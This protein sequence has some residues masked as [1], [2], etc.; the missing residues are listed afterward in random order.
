MLNRKEITLALGGGG[1][2]GSAH[3][4][5][6]RVLERQGYTVCA[7]AGTSAGGLWG[8]LYAYG[9]SPDEIQR[10]IK[11]LDP[12]TIY[13]RQPN[14]GPAWLGLS[15]LTRML[16]DALGDI[17]FEELHI[18]FA[19]TAVDI[20]TAEYVVLRSGRV[21]DAVLATIA[22]PGVFP[23]RKVNGRL[24]IDGGVLD[25]VPVSLARSLAPSGLP[26][27]AVVLSPP[28]DY[29]DG[30][31][32]A[33]LLGSM[34]LLSSF[35]EYLGRFRITQV[36]NIMMRSVDIS[37]AM[38]TELLLEVEKP[39]VVIRPTVPQLSLLDRVDADQISLLGE[40]AAER[41]ASDLEQATRLTAWL[42]RRLAAHHTPVIRTPTRA[43]FPDFDLLPPLV[44]PETVSS[45]S[46]SPVA[47]AKSVLAALVTQAGL[48]MTG[49][50]STPAPKKPALPD[51][52]GQS[53][54]SEMAQP[55]RPAQSKPTQPDQV[56]PPKYGS[57]PDGA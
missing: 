11:Q 19:V 29:W 47:Q 5:V 35:S 46:S 43:D 42:R 53:S 34:P 3:T 24:L 12:A 49:P 4:G 44:L 25:Q 37:S 31:E 2:K 33:G 17:T 56:G 48:L 45:A 15:G 10:R 8:S 21:V 52:N 1:V 27:V 51:S 6:L 50:T 16:E 20:D 32:T 39:D 22:V 57:T 41:A 30:I 9:Y 26:V 13:N 28:V 18:P 54:P 55:S 7:I 23:P 14:S 38:M 36:L 40:K